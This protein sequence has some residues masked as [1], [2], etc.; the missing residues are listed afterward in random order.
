[1]PPLVMVGQAKKR[2]GQAHDQAAE[3]YHDDQH[4]GRVE[5]H[6]L[7]IGDRSRIIRGKIL[8]PRAKP[9]GRE[10]QIRSGRLP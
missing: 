10:A 7:Q 1:M 2:G 5:L 6:P 4:H 8:I 9:Q 3:K